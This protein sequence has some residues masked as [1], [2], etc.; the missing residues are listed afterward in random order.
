MI[1]T[2]R[3][4]SAAGTVALALAVHSLAAAVPPASGDVLTLDEAV[5]LAL[6][7]SPRLGIAALDVH[8][9]EEK[10]AA[11]RTRRLPSL[12]LQAMAGT[13]LNPIRVT[14]PAGASGRSPRRG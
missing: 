7:N 13:T 4:V 1:G 2:T 3:R 10:L 9:A 11:A 8:R 14:F 5:A 12:E 6:Q